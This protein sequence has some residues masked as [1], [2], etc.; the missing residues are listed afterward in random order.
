M[1]DC[2]TCIKISVLYWCQP[3]VTSHMLHIF[4]LLQVFSVNK[5]QL[6]LS[7]PPF[8]SLLA[9][10]VDPGDVALLQIYFW[11]NNIDLFLVLCDQFICIIY[12][13]GSFFIVFGSSRILK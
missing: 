7:D 10:G 3:G 13:L 4:P 1:W 11:G 8:I 5:D 2:T 9:K 6:F 12:V